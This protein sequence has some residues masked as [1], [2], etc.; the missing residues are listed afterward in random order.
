MSTQRRLKIFRWKR[1]G[2]NTMLFLAPAAIVFLTSIQS[3]ARMEDALIALKLWGI[4]TLIDWLVKF[5][6]AGK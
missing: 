2:K 4:N 5:R 1:W 3:G 6:E